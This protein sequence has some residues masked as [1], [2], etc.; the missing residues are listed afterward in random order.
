MSGR[1]HARRRPHSG[2]GHEE[3]HENHE[4]WLVTYADMLT[5]LMV[6]FIVLFAM[7]QVDQHKFAQLKQGLAAGFGA[8]TVFDG[9]TGALA[10]N[11][12]ENSP[13]DINPGLANQK[14][15]PQQ[16]AIKDAVQ[17][18]DLAQRQAQ[19]RRAQ[20]EVD[21]FGRLRKKIN[22]ALA[23]S[24][25]AAGVRFTIDERGLVITIVTSSVVFAGDRA[26][27][28]PIGQRILD[29]VGPPLRT[30]PNGIE[31]DGHTNQ[32]RVPTRFYPTAWELSTARAS[33]VVR[34]LVDRGGLDPRRMSAVGFAGE[35]PLYGSSDPR[36]P[37]LNRR[38]EIVVLS[39]LPVG[40]RA[41]L[42][43]AASRVPN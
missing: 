6:L 39:G 12:Q 3:E 43:V 1:G 10:D 19:L 30:L 27:L 33:T 11:G 40:D 25:L 38:V 24:K 28:L 29:A 18:A 22:Q 4:R 21:Q 31:V 36:A 35:R 7:S 23:R 9:G 16:K 2:G 26:E 42:P 8:P 37:V 5:L 41:L 14:D 17:A 32:L 20:A 15:P 34:Y 13:V